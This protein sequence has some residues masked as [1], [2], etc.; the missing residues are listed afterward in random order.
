MNRKSP[1][2]IREINRNQ[3]KSLSQ[4][5][6]KK[7]KKKRKSSI[8]ISIKN[9]NPKAFNKNKRNKSVNNKN[10]HKYKFW[11][12]K[13]RL[14]Q[15]LRNFWK[16]S[17]KWEKKRNLS[18]RSLKCTMT[19]KD[20]KSDLKNF[21]NKTSTLSKKSNNLKKSYMKCNPTSLDP[22]LSLFYFI[23]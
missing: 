16:R 23:F 6:R 18:T 19:L 4:S 20:L 21:N 15:L 1:I 5:N 7:Y 17:S 10:P 2:K 14:P 9:N 11:T 12:H 3:N 8:R 22:H 13:I